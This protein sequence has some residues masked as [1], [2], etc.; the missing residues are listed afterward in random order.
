[1]TAKTSSAVNK[2]GFVFGD[3]VTSGDKPNTV[4][5][6]TEVKTYLVAYNNGEGRKQVR[7]V[8]KAPDSPAVFLLQEKISGSFVAT[9]GTEW[10]NKAFCTKLNEK[11]LEAPKD[12]GAE[13]AAQV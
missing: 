8:F 12:A 1:M 4:N 2:S 13:G 9:S 7:I 5:D 6:L 3:D 11:G 10:F